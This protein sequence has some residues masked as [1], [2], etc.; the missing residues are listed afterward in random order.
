MSTR[1]LLIVL[2]IVS[3]GLTGVAWF[4]ATHEKVTDKAW[5][6]YTG[7]AKRNPWLAA[8]RFLDHFGARNKEVRALP[9]LRNL[10]PR[11]TLI[12]PEAHHTI[13][14]SL[15]DAVVAWVA[16]GGHLIV[17]GEHA[18]LDDSLVSAFGIER[19]A[20]DFSAF[21]PDEDEDYKESPY[22]RISLPGSTSPANV[23]F[24]AY[25][26]LR[27][28]DA[29]F[30]AD[31]TF[32]TYVIAK[33]YGT[34]SVIVVNDLDYL[35]NSMIGALDHAAFLLDL[36]R[37]TV[38]LSDGNDAPFA[39]PVLLFNQ[40]AK[41]SLLTWLEKHAWAPLAGA[42]LALIVWLWRV[43][44]RF[45]PLIPDP[46]RAR[47]R[48]LDHLRASGR[49]LWA[50][51]HAPRLLESARE[52]CLRRIARAMPEFLTATTDARAAYLIDMLGLTPEQAQR[53]LQ[54]QRGARMLQFLHTIRLYQ[55]VYAR[56]ATK[57]LSSQS[58]AS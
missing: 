21:D 46:Q 6:G 26:S 27:A 30:Q 55:S 36:L 37:A 4:L 5:T 15:R 19:L 3:L 9:D 45:G 25:M 44:P 20:T 31:G 58:S 40:P 41:L 18:G 16:D 12:I 13:T 57:P 43:V 32:G 54:P 51:G 8:Q 35:K 33:R 11:A 42:A 48:L 14:D 34:G 22:T 39:Q 23:Q 1:E 53:I 29:G 38:N 2:L 24:E 47:R 28:D 49:F 10:P 17:E 52:S 7:E 56:L 50:N